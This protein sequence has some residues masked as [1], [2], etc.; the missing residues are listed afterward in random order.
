M[1]KKLIFYEGKFYKLN[2]EELR[3]L[4]SENC[5]VGPEAQIREIIKKEDMGE[6]FQTIKNWY[7][8]TS[9]T[10]DIQSL[11]KIAHFYDVP[12]TNI[13][14]ETDQTWEYIEEAK[15]SNI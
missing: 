1:A 7:Y 8:G 9:G 2:N 3:K 12:V 11:E 4:I 6:K 10:E 15:H 5:D 14:T 13:L